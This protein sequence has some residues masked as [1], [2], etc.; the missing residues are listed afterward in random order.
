MT[1]PLKVITTVMTKYGSNRPFVRTNRA[2]LGSVCN[3]VSTTV[4]KPGSGYDFGSAV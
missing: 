4:A 1:L 2:I 3:L